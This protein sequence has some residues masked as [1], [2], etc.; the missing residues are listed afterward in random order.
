MSEVLSGLNNSVTWE[1]LPCAPR[2]IY[3]NF[4]ARDNNPNWGRTGN[5]FMEI[6]V[7]DTGPFAVSYPNGA[8][9][10]NE[11][12]TPTITWTENGTSAHCPMVDILLSKDNGV[13][14][15][16][17]ASAVVNDGSQSVTLPSGSSSDARILIQCSVGG[18]FKSASTFFD[19]SDAVFN[20]QIAL[21]VDLVDFKVERFMDK[22]VNVIWATENENNN[23]YFDVERSQD[24]YDFH[25]IG[26]I[27]GFGNS[28]IRRNYSFID[29]LPLGGLSYYRLKQVDL[30]GEFDFSQIRPI[31]FSGLLSTILVYPNPSS[32]LL[33]VQIADNELGSA[34]RIY[35]Q[36]GRLV[37]SSILSKPTIDISNL[38]N[39]LY[40]LSLTAGDKT[41]LEKVIINK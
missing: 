30:G 31:N 41:Y 5:E 36:I 11:G 29:D 25:A 15:T 22:K 26:R 1:K 7:E 14:F 9:T 8:E 4:N 16:I 23:Q 6:T 19:V 34:L 20:I 27:N 38:P 18:N 13:T 24:G 21:P 39:G 28:T 2:T 35:D 17:L 10:L 3:F 32:G 33:S 40:H 12:G 37:H